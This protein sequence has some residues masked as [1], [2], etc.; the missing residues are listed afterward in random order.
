LQ[1]VGAKF[2]FNG[3]GLVTTFFQVTKGADFLNIYHRAEN[4]Y[5]A[6][7]F[8]NAECEI[9]NAESLLL[10]ATQEIMQLSSTI[11]ELA[12]FLYICYK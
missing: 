8:K 7:R 9:R 11:G 1:E 5:W 10:L 6:E 2:V 3:T 4:A 12:G